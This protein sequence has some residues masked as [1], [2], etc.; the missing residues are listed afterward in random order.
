MGF[1][2]TTLDIPDALFRRTKAHAAMRG[3]SLRDFIITAI[4]HNLGRSGKKGWRT[5]F[6][7]A[8][9]EAVDGVDETIRGEFS[10]VDPGEWT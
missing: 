10:R 6:G 1:M 3:E 4:R 5:V 9:T 8:S 2:K 7:K